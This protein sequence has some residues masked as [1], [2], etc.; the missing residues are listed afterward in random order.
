MTASAAK[1]D[2]LSEDPLPLR[3]GVPGNSSLQSVLKYQLELDSSI[4]VKIHTN[5]K[6]QHQIILSY[7]SSAIILIKNNLNIFNYSPDESFTNALDPLV[8]CSSAP[9][10]PAIM[11][12]FGLGY[13]FFE[14]SA[15]LPS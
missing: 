9:Q 8:P 15:L 13:I 3:T 12:R 1:N 7:S 6:I 14:I 5:V 4:G 11:V 10:W 2:L